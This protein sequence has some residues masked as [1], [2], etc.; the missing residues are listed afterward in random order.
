MTVMHKGTHTGYDTVHLSK[1]KRD[2]MPPQE[3]QGKYSSPSGA[4]EL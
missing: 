1:P 4:K 2:H 3:G